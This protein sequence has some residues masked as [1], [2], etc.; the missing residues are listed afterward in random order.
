MQ[1]QIDPLKCN[2]LFLST[3]CPDI[4]IIGFFIKRCEIFFYKEIPSG[5]IQEEP[6]SSVDPDLFL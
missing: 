3:Y 2:A 1:N 5:E 6:L 4:F